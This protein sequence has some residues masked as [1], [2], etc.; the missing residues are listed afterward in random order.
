MDIK[1]NENNPVLF[2]L[3]EIHSRC[4]F[5]QTK[6]KEVQ[7]DTLCKQ[8]PKESEVAILISEKMDFKTKSTTRDKDTVPHFHLTD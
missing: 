2:C 8:E 3:Q 5:I 1:T 6:S 7:K 4:I